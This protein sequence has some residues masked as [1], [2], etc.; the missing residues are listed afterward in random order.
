[1]A[2]ETGDFIADLRKE[3]LSAQ[4]TRYRHTQQKFL[5][6]IGLLGIGK[7]LPM[8][9]DYIVLFY[10]A[11]IVAFAFDLY[12]TGENFGIRRIG[13]FIFWCKGASKE[14]RYWEFLLPKNRDPFAAFAGPLMSFFILC[15]SSLWILKHER[16]S[17][18]FAIWF[19]FN[20][21][22][23]MLVCA[24]DCFLKKKLRKFERDTLYLENQFR[25][26]LFRKTA[27]NVKT[28]SFKSILGQF[29]SLCRQ[30]RESIVEE[31]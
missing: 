23:L 31:K 18:E 30:E 8:I 27:I 7:L 2:R 24:K 17:D 11:P 9:S 28:N 21:V 1:M 12:I 4:R 16:P 13:T 22:L 5:F 19:A 6:V 3:I 20:I 26:T 14:E 25:E 29:R 15:I 10:L